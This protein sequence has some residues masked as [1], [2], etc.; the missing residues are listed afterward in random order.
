M[1]YYPRAASMT[2][3]SAAS[4]A[5]FAR[6]EAHPEPVYLAKLVVD[7]AR[8]TALHRDVAADAPRVTILRSCLMRPEQAGW[9]EEIV[10]RLERAATV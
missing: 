1:T 9:V 3:I 8:F 6:A 2:A 7:A 5:I 4:D 10:A